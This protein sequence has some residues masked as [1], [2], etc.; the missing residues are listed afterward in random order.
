MRVS[1]SLAE[2]WRL[3]TEATFFEDE[4]LLL[5][6]GNV[7]LVPLEEEEEGEEVAVTMSEL[8]LCGRDTGEEE[9]REELVDVGLTSCRLDAEV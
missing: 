1:E 2:K 5:E 4:P 7:R 3:L 9:A 8:F 6:M